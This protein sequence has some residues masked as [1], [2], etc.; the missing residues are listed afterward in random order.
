MEQA[1]A[2]QRARAEEL[3]RQLWSVLKQRR[4][5]TRQA[6]IEAENA[7]NDA[8]KRGLNSHLPTLDEVFAAGPYEVGS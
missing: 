7:L 5:E 1:E 3:Q 8:V 4:D 2:A 6:A